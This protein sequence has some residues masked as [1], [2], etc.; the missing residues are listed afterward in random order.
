MEEI[1]PSNIVSGRTRNKHIDWAEAEEKSKAAGDDL[2]DD[3]DE[4]DED[5]EAED[6]DE[7]QMRDW[8]PSRHSTWVDDA[9]CFSTTQPK[10]E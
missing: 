1:D 4:D 8:A 10:V 9:T 3:E 6:D 5:F 7:D 2:D